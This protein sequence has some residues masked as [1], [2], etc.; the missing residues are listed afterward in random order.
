MNLGTLSGMGFVFWGI[1]NIGVFGLSKIM[2]KENFDY[3]FAYTG[4][5]KFLQPLKSMMAGKD[6]AN[7]AWTSTSLIVGGF[8][9]QQRVGSVCAFKLFGL[10]LLSSYLATSALGPASRVSKLNI[11][12]MMPMRWDS[13]D[14]DKRSMVGADLMAGTCLYFVLFSHGLFIPGAA[15]AAFDV[16]YYGP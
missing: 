6:L 13:I 7:V 10:A 4:N 3:H 16:A 2:H 11:R 5:G 12:S 1:C 8:Y 9:L 14:T 15:F